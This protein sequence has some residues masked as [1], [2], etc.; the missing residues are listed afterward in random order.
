MIKKITVITMVAAGLFLA[1]GTAFACKGKMA[2]AGKSCGHKMANKKAQAG[3]HM[4]KA[5]NGTVRR[6]L[7]TDEIELTQQQRFALFEVRENTEKT[8]R[9]L[10]QQRRTAGKGLKQNLW[11]QTP[12]YS[13]AKTAADNIAAIQAQISKAYI[14]GIEQARAVLT[15]AQKTKMAELRT[16]RKQENTEVK[17]S[18]KGGKGAQS[19]S[20]AAPAR[21]KR[22][23]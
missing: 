18:R 3:C 16:Q 10:S 22:N 11:G 12:D 20:A 6:I 4:E 5:F 9:G 1:Q 8:V 21:Q 2:G 17:G 19:G 13:A 14:D 7:A 15:P 23:R